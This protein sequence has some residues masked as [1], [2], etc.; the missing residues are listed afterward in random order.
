MTGIE[1][2]PA[3][4]GA[5]LLVGVI[6]VVYQIFQMVVIDARARNLK[7]PGSWGVFTL[8]S[9]NL[10]LY[11][12]GRR[13]YPVVRMTDADRKEMARRKK[14]IGVSLAFMAAGAIGIVLYGTLTSSL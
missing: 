1:I 14:V 10:I 8:G 11:L 3:V 13:R 6:S 2:I 7:H 4:G 5:F 12:I 9:D